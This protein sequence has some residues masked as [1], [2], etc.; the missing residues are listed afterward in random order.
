MRW[1]TGSLYHIM[2]ILFK[3]VASFRSQHTTQR[4]IRYGCLV[5]YGIFMY[6]QTKVFY[7]KFTFGKVE[8]ARLVHSIV[9]AFV[10]WGYFSV[11]IW[12]ISTYNCICFLERLS[13]YILKINHKINMQNNICKYYQNLTQELIKECVA[14]YEQYH[15]QQWTTMMIVWH[16][17]NE[18][19][20]V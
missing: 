2:Y 6:N 5:Q 13:W 19:I 14:S 11:S 9:I 17:Y 1:A 8:S 3:N 15:K 4:Q 20:H 16:C 7:S 10:F 12:L 18:L